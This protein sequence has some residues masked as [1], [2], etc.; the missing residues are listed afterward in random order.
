MKTV[1]EYLKNDW[2]ENSGHIT[3]KAILTNACDR[4]GS[5]QDYAD[6]EGMYMAVYSFWEHNVEC[7][8]EVENEKWVGYELEVSIEKQQ[9]LMNNYGVNTI[10]LIVPQW[11]MNLKVNNERH[12]SNIF[13]K[14]L[15]R[16]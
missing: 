1:R 7:F 3:K 16:L 5:Y 14:Y 8:D 4:I 10:K 2:E 11:V 13:R 6:I 15:R 12:A 9:W